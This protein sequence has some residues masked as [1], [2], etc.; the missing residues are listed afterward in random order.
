M[1]RTKL[2]MGALLAGASL[3]LPT[4]AAALFVCTV[5]KTSTPKLASWSAS[6]IVSFVRSSP[7]RMTS[8]FSRPALRIAAAKLEACGDRKST[9]LNS[10]HMSES[11][12]PS[13][14]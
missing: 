1:S 9:R 4:V 8:A 12:M 5:P 6:F 14:A 11:R 3:V 10:S 7:I 13:S 2:F